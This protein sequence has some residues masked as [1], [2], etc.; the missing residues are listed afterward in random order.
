MTTSIVDTSFVVGLM[1]QDDPHHSRIAMAARALRTR[2]WLP[3][4]AMVEVCSLL[5]HRRGAR[6]DAEFVAG[7]ARPDAAFALLDAIP[8]DYLRSAEIMAKYGDSGVDFVDAVIV[9]VAERLNI[10]TILSLDHR[11]FGIVRPR[12]RA[13]FELLPAPE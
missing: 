2:P 12:H 4:V 8:A 10:G 11:H 7:L 1:N 6:V 13:A 9:A 3:T 5:H